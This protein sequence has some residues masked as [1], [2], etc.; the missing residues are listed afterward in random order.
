M[1]I[2]DRLKKVLN[3]EL[4]NIG[5]P[6]PLLLKSGDAFFMHYN[7]LHSMMENSK[8]DQTQI[9]IFARLHHCSRRLEQLVGRCKKQAMI[10]PFLEYPGVKRYCFY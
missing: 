10:E 7:E 2:L 5:F 9:Y 4:D 6:V 3:V 8:S 1:T